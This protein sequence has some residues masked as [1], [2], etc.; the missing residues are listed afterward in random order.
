MHPFIED[1]RGQ[2]ADR[3]RRHGVRRLELVG[4]VLP[5]LPDA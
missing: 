4:S 5:E 2:I 1:H 3:C